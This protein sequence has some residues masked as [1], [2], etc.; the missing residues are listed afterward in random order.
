M[1]PLGTRLRWAALMA[2]GALALHELRFAAYSGGHIHEDVVDARHAHIELA[3]V[4]CGVLLAAALG[5]LLAR[6]VRAWHTGRTESQATR[7]LRIWP[8]AALGL[9]AA[10]LGQEIAEIALAGQEPVALRDLL[11]HGGWVAVPLA[12]AIGAVVAFL[13]RG[14]EAVLELAAR[15][16][17]PS[18]GVRM[19]I[20]A[21][22]RASLV[23]LRRADPLAESIG[24]RGPPRIPARP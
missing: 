7:A 13:S 8:L 11:G 23:L 14:A 3:F 6:L 10:Y 12:A 16:G 1:R 19:P 9:L 15:V 2:A 24:G 18:R 4:V 22:G 5:D 17:R 21:R 20:A